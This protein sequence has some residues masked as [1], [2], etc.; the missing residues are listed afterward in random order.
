[1]ASSSSPSKKVVDS[2]KRTKTSLPLSSLLVNAIFMVQAII[3]DWR[4]G[5]LIWIYWFQGY[6]IILLGL[7][8][9]RKKPHW[10]V[11]FGIMTVYGIFLSALTFPSENVTYVKNGVEVSA[12]EFTVLSNTQWKVV[13]LNII[14]LLVGYLIANFVTK[15]KT[16][17]SGAQVAKRLTPLHLTIIFASFTSWSVI[18]F[19]VLRSVF[20]VSMELSAGWL[21]HKAVSLKTKTS[22]KIQRFK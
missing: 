21:G 16:T 9:N 20:D 4:L 7:W 14:A 2:G 11:M 8:A 22:A 17:Y 15:D 1:M 3:L 5:T 10:F 6:V 13:L 18:L 19:L 12:Q